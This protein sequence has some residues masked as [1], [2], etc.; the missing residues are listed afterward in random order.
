MAAAVGMSGKTYEK[1]ATVVAAAAADTYG[2]LVGAMDTLYNHS[3]VQVIGCGWAGAFVP[4]GV[5]AEPWWSDERQLY[6]QP[7]EG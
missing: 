7:A 4:A 2:D 5:W 6:P 1:I 3:E